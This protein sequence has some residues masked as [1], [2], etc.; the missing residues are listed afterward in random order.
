MQVNYR[1]HLGLATRHANCPMSREK[2]LTIHLMF[3]Y[4]HCQELGVG[5][6]G[7]QCLC[8]K[9]QNFERWSLD[10]NLFAVMYDFF[11]FRS[12]MQEASGGI[13]NIHKDKSTLVGLSPWFFLFSLFPLLICANTR[14]SLDVV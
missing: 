10:Q 12:C 8:E 4:W 14:K 13:G 3:L 5:L 9:N 11:F 1:T 6:F 2:K 7:S